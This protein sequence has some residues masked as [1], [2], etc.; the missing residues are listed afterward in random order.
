M[1]DLKSFIEKMSDATSTK[2]NTFKSK[3]H[4][5]AFAAELENSGYTELD[6]QSDFAKE[7][8]VHSSMSL[9]P[10]LMGKYVFIPQPFGS[11]MTPDFI[12]V[13]DGRVLY[14]EMKRSNQK[15]IS[16]NTG[17]PKND[18]FYIFDSG[19]LGRIIFFGDHHPAYGGLED[20]YND[21][22]DKLKLE[23]DRLF[24]STP[25]NFYMRKMINDKGSYDKDA[26]Y[27]KALNKVEVL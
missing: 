18:Y 23:S 7:I 9:V 10:E 14:V 26:L 15:N 20:Q 8:K 4:E 21:L 1:K 17:Y 16:W 19:K 24:G 27:K 12:V 22:V 3:D 2:A 5:D 25:F 11:Q 6:Y 13:I